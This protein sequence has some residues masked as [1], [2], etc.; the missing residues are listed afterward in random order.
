MLRAGPRLRRRAP[1]VSAAL[2]AVAA[3]VTAFSAAA[4]AATGVSVSPTPVSWTPTL[5][6][7][8]TDGTVEQIRQVVQCGGTMYAVGRFTS[9]AQNGVTYARNNAF[10]FS[11]TSGALNSWS[12]NV[13]GQVDSVALSTDCSTAYLGGAFSSVSGTAVTNIASVS[14]ATAAVNT[15]F[16]HAANKEVEA[17]LLVPGPHLLVGGYFTTLNNSTHKYLASLNP[18][19]GADDG[20]VNLNISGNYSYTD[21]GGNVAKPNPTRVYNYSLSPNKSR[22]LVMGDFTSVGGLGRQ[23]IF[24]LDLGASATKVDPWYSAEFNGH[25]ASVEPFYLQDASWAPDESKVY[26]VATGYKP[27]NGSGYVKTNPRTG[28]CDAAAAF[29]TTANSYLTH[30][31]V[32]YT[33]CDTL[34]STA[35]DAGAVYVGGHERWLDNPS[36]CDTFLASGASRT[37]SPGMGGIDPVSGKAILDGKGINTATGDLVDKYSRGRGLGA[38]DMLLTSAGLWIASDNAQNTDGCGKTATGA[39]SYKHSG[40]CFLPYAG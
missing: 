12:P 30:A 39:T 24:M 9:I 6:T 34:F 3:A 16:A 26:T 28:L 40:L 10:S 14:T 22:L 27:A 36:G 18:A 2:S 29:P 13:N 11:A 4:T 5:A 23:Q 38:D 35:A 1:F 17:L 32:N 7:S 20:Y 33:G 19:S 15:S 8:G 21:D 31:W 25:C 37:D